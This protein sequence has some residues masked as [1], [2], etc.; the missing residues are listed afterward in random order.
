LRALAD[1]GYRDVGELANQG[2]QPTWPSS[3]DVSLLGVP[4]PSLTQIDHV[5]VG[6]RLAAIGMHTRE[7]PGSEHRAVVAEVAPK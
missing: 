5:L 2:W 4:L 1:D 6:P 3:G 7:I